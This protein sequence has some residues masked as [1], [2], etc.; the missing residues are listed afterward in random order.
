VSLATD[1]VLTLCAPYLHAGQTIV[2]DNYYTS[3]P[4]ANVGTL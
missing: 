3:L 2:T 4:L 1:I